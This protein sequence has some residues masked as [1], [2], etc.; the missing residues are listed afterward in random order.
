[1]SKQK[2]LYFP[3]KNISIFSNTAGIFFLN[4]HMTRHKVNFNKYER[5]GFIQSTDI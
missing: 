3:I 5:I 1:M 4:D 2:I